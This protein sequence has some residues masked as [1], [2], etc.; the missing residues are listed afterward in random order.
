[1]GAR[2]ARLVAVVFPDLADIEATARYAGAAAAFFRTRG[3]PTLEVAKLFRGRPAESLV[4]NARDS[5]PSEA[6]HAELAERTLDLLREKGWLSGG[7]RD[8][9][10]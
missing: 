2:E 9:N 5:H 4:V 8:P 3:V 1:V 6:V 7:A 10:R